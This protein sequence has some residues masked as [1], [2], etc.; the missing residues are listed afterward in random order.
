MARSASL[1]RS[2]PVPEWKNYSIDY[3]VVKREGTKLVRK[4]HALHQ[5]YINRVS[6]VI[7]GPSEVSSDRSSVSSSQAASLARGLE[8]E[9]S[10]TTLSELYRAKKIQLVLEF[11]NLLAL[12]LHSADLF[13]GLKNLELVKNFESNSNN[14]K[15]NNK[16]LVS[17]VFA[18]Q[19]RLDEYR[20]TLHTESKLNNDF[21]QGMVD[22]QAGSEVPTFNNDGL[23]MLNLD[24]V[25]RNLATARS[26]N[27]RLG[28]KLSDIRN[29]VF[30]R[31]VHFADHQKDITLYVLYAFN[32]ALLRHSDISEYCSPPADISYT[33]LLH[34]VNGKRS[35]S[36][37]S[38]TLEDSTYEL[39]PDAL[40]LA[41]KDL[42]MSFS[43]RVAFLSSIYRSILGAPFDGAAIK[44]I[45]GNT[46]Y[47]REFVYFGMTQE[48]DFKAY[49]GVLDVSSSLSET[50]FL[51]NPVSFWSFSA[52]C[53]Y[54]LIRNIQRIARANSGHADVVEQLILLVGS[55]R[56]LIYNR[57]QLQSAYQSG[58]L[59][60]YLTPPMVLKR[61]KTDPKPLLAKEFDRQSM[62]C[63]S[64]AYFL[65]APQYAY[66]VCFELEELFS[67]TENKD[68]DHKATLKLVERA[69][70]EAERKRTCCDN[71]ALHK[72]TY[73]D[74]QRKS[75]HSP[76]PVALISDG[77]LYLAVGVCGTLQRV[78]DADLSTQDIQTLE[79]REVPTSSNKLLKELFTK[80]N[81]PIVSVL[82]SVERY[83]FQDKKLCYLTLHRNVKFTNSIKEKYFNYAILELRW[84]SADEKLPMIINQFVELEYLYEVPEFEFFECGKLCL[85]TETPQNGNFGW[86]EKITSRKFSL[87]AITE[88]RL[89]R[90]QHKRALI[91]KLQQESQKVTPDQSQIGKSRYWNEFDD[92]PEEWG[93]QNGFYVD[94]TETELFSDGVIHFLLD[95]TYK[96]HS[97]LGKA[98]TALFGA[99]PRGRISSYY[100]EEE[101]LSRDDTSYDDQSILDRSG[102]S[103]PFY[104]AIEAHK[105]ST[106]KVDPDSERIENHDMIA[107]F[108]YFVLPTVAA[109]VTGSALGV[110]Y[111]YLLNPTYDHSGSSYTALVVCVGVGLLMSF[112]LTLLSV[113]FLYG[114]IVSAPL[115]HHCFVWLVF[116]AVLIASL[117]IAMEFLEVK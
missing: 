115:H 63:V 83:V 60:H 44:Q 102:S 69:V 20:S 92:N 76:P 90:S 58:T 37:T 35:L 28:A 70:L 22:F 61:L 24:V 16:T 108:F 79:N 5:N 41:Q 25:S 17:E 50:R 75:T 78:V 112:I 62:R 3:L 86:W 71:R 106:K 32:K 38:F 33:D 116:G 91:Q 111:S 89:Y 48:S 47:E 85:G 31:L 52:Q 23:R 110:A 26:K 96:L 104:G 88:N 46:I 10:G 39:D 98:R 51:S 117:T 73:Y 72:V 45:F 103:V 11:G 30:F 56:T 4:L 7:D 13:V 43:E 101:G 80:Q 36:M 1:I 21:L 12:N 9:F 6:S 29:D 57:Q 68:Q 93:D 94:V 49:G 109:I 107:S 81:T 113:V 34:L 114:R 40:W 74:S 105:R 82:S 59:S 54:M 18:L 87:R 42:L 55:Q 99:P 84:D 2:S 97:A 67:P 100:L 95:L 19:Q 64:S 65:V 27:S 8:S 15:S 53:Q 66:E 14:F 77:D